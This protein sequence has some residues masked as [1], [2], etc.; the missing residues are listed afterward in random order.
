MQTIKAEKPDTDKNGTLDAVESADEFKLD[1]QSRIKR[2]K[3]YLVLQ[4]EIACRIF[5]SGKIPSGSFLFLCEK[6][7]FQMRLLETVPDHNL[8]KEMIENYFASD[9]SLPDKN[10]LH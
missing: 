3:D 7:L 2:D 6:Y 5:R 4:I 8:I 10:M 9:F 1:E